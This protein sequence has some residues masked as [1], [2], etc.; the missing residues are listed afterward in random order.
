[1]DAMID[2]LHAA[3][4]I[5]PA[6]QV[7]YPGEIEFETAIERAKHGIPID[8]RLFAELLGLAAQLELDMP[9]S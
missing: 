1:M 4:M 5:D 7:H 8:D 6:Q 2:A 9:Q 3:P